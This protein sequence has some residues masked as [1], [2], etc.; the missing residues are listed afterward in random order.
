MF[1]K[2]WQTSSFKGKWT[3]SPKERFEYF[4]N[5]AIWN[6]KLWSG[7][8]DELTFLAHRSLHFAC[9]CRI[10]QLLP[11]I[12][13]VAENQ[14][15]AAYL[16][17]KAE[18][19]S[20]QIGHPRILIVADYHLQYS[21]KMRK[22]NFPDWVKFIQINHGLGLAKAHYYNVAND[23]PMDLYLVS[24]NLARER[25][26]QQGI[27]SVIDV[28]FP[29]LDPLFDGS[30]EREEI[31]QQLG[32]PSDKPILLY[33]PTWG[34]LSSLPRVMPLMTKIATNGD[35]TILIK[36]HGNSIDE[37]EDLKQ[38][39]G[40]TETE[41]IY[42]LTDPD[43]TPLLFIA[44]LLISDVSSIVFEFA[45][46]NK[47]IILI[48]PPATEWQP[49]VI[50]PTWWQVGY[51][52]NEAEQLPFAIPALLREDFP[53]QQDFRAQFIEN[54]GI[55][56]DGKATERA[57]EAISYFCKEGGAWRR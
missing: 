26:L 9:F 47:P 5:R 57:A 53:E 14:L 29:K 43:C 32:M 19:F 33:A 24:C 54:I 45:L 50:D 4:I 56:L 37:L 46:L 15:I 12:R 25:F 6:T 40:L 22:I 28:G 18:V 41:G 13:I 11:Q 52:L 48:H 3:G 16:Q 20:P 23:I 36:I 38:T 10:H 1:L 30:L 55:K 8:L 44:D 35:Y 31:C 27:T 2:A 39:P 42:F 21:R 17:S 7:S 34:G 49:I 51:A